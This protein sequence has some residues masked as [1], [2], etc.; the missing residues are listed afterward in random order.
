[1]EVVSV[2]QTRIKLMAEYYNI[3]LWW[4]D[5]RRVGPIELDDLP[6]SDALK[7]DLAEW[8]KVYYKQLNPD[9]PKDDT[10]FLKGSEKVRFE[11]QGRTLWG[12]LQRELGSDYHV[13]YFSELD[14]RLHEPESSSDQ[15]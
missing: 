2:T 3:I 12:R 9:D 13:S 6:I 10:H 15:S 4:N 8:G 7:T 14:H 5:G 1:M 11:R